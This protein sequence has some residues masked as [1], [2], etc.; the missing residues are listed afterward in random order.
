LTK[1]QILHRSIDNYENAFPFHSPD[2][3]EEMKNQ[4]SMAWHHLPMS[5]WSKQDDIFPN[6]LKNWDI[7]VDGERIK[8]KDFPAVFCKQ[9]P[10]KSHNTFSF[11]VKFGDVFGQLMILICLGWIGVYYRRVKKADV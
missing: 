7:I 3:I 9:V 6:T 5:L 4:R 2:K 11:Y 1:E 8:W 10:L